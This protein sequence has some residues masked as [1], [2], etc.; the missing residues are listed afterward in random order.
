MTPG[1]DYIGA[2]CGVVILDEDGKLL[3]MKRTPNTRNDHGMWS[4]PGGKI[5]FGELAEDAIRREVDEELGLQLGD[6][7]YLGYIDHIIEKDQH[8]WVSQIF[9]AHSG[10]YSGD[11][12]NKEPE[13]CELIEWFSLDDLPSPLSGIVERVAELMQEKNVPRGTFEKHA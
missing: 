10:T 12:L 1:K 9:I 3:M 11:Y 8:H 2:A 4:I 5:E 6:L 13:K 7:E